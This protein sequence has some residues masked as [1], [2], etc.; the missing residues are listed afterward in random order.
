M[1]DWDDYHAYKNT[2]E[3]LDDENN[4]GGTSGGGCG[5]AVI[6]FLAFL[7]IYFVANG[8]SW[9]AIDCLLGFGFIVFLI[10]RSMF[11]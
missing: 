1:S 11:R 8:A 9:D 4:G 5:C 2:C 10:V 6:V 7:L 3:D